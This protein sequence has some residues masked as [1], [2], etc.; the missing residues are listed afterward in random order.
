[1]SNLHR[2]NTEPFIRLNAKHAI[3]REGLNWEHACDCC[4]LVT[5]NRRMLFVQ[6][7]SHVPDEHGRMF[8]G[9][10]NVRR[11][12]S[13]C[14]DECRVDWYRLGSRDDFWP[15]GGPG[16]AG[17]ATENIIGLGHLQPDL[18]LRIVAYAVDVVGPAQISVRPIDD[19][20]VYSGAE[21]NAYW[22]APA[23]HVRHVQVA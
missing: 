12:W 14:S 17:T 7:R 4:G 11:R 10:V 15:V 21:L 20:Q 23:T 22:R 1:M 5:P 16:P 3:E 9:R 8:Y 19:H 13:F 18:W 6:L 2:I